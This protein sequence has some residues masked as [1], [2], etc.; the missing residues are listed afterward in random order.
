MRVLVISDSSP[1]PL[2]SGDRI[3]E[4][5]LIRR[6]ADQH[7]VW[8]AAL[9]ERPS[10]EEGLAHLE[11]FCAGV[12]FS[13]AHRRHPLIHVPGLLKYGLTGKPLEL[14]FQQ[15]DE[16]ARKIRRLVARIYFDLVIIINSH[17]ALYLELLDKQSRLKSV[18]MLENIEFAQYESIYRI[19]RKPVRK[20]RAWINHRMMRRWEPRYAEHF[21]HCITV[22]YVDR[23]I[24]I[25]A[26]PR[27]KIDVIPNGVDTKHYQ[28]LPWS[29]E[30]QSMIFIGKMSYPPCSDAAIYFCNEIFPIIRNRVNSAEFWIVGREP[31]REVENLAGDGVRVTGWV[32]DVIPYYGRSAVCCPTARWRRN[33]IKDPGGDGAWTTSRFNQHRLRRT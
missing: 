30:T 26:N 4:Y 23:D 7:E 32:E 15:S 29:H 20:V 27:L 22:S 11:R 14:K 2:I 13:H 9:L 28:T 5:N 8:L 17:T 25:K 33:K 1:Y 24:L 16:L 3:R 18:L 10:D 19:E 21:D 6:M 12:E 31:P